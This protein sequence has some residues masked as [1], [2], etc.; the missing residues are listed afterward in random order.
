MAIRTVCH[1]IYEG[2]PCEGAPCEGL[3]YKSTP[4]EIVLYKALL[5]KLRRM[6][7]RRMKLRSAVLVIIS[8]VLAVL[9]SIL[10]QCKRS[11]SGAM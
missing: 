2:A 9:W 10:V 3:L 7:L 8:A 11:V 1:R 6:T 4:Y 5:K